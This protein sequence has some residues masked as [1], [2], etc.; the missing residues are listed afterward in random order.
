L[1][2]NSKAVGNVNDEKS[3]CYSIASIF[4]SALFNIHQSGVLAA[5]TGCYMADGT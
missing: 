5:L 1:T 4:Y 2:E 3:V